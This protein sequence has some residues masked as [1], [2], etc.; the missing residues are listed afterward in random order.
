MLLACVGALAA[1]ASS[2]SAVRSASDA[3]IWVET[4]R[5]FGFL[6][7]AGM[8][9]LLAL[10][11]RL[12]AGVWELALLHKLA[13]SISA[14]VLVGVAEASSAGVVDSVLAVTIAVAYVL[15]HGWLSWRVREGR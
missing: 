3:T 12:S 8:F 13:M 10:R 7:F 15:T 9:A 2:I 5:M 11:P 4:W 6:V 1:F 14:G